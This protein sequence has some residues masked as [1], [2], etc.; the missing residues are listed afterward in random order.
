MALDATQK[1][2]SP[3][4]AGV[5]VNP[6]GFGKSMGSNF[7]GMYGGVIGS[8]IGAAKA[9]RAGQER[10]RIASESETPAFG[11]LAYLAVTANE[12]A[13]VEVKSKV[14][15]AYLDEVIARVARSEVASVELDG[16][17]L[18]ALPLTVTFSSGDRWEL[19]VPKPSK[20][21]A[22]EVVQALDG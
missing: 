5:K 15:T 10:A 2:S 18:Y 13:L 21:H 3:Q 19:E 9:M 6:R 8:G 14:V 20:K 7:S 1:L 11:R 16:G 12:L 22:K 4:L 17:G